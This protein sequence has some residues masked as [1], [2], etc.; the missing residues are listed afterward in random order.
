MIEGISWNL[1]DLEKIEK[2]WS[3]FSAFSCGGGSSLG[4]KMA[5]FN[6]VGAND[7]DP[8]MEWHYKKNLHPA[9]YFLCPVKHL[10]NKELPEEM[11]RLDIL[12]GSP[13]CSTF[14][15]AGNREKDWGKKKK[16]REGQAVQ[17]LDEL[18]FDF[19]ALANK[20]KPKIVVAE[21]VPGIIKG[22]AKFYAKKICEEFAN[23]GYDTQ[24]FLLNAKNCSVPQ[25]RERVFFISARSELGLPKLSLSPK[26]KQI[27]VWDAIKDI[28]NLTNE[29]IRSTAPAKIDLDYWHKVK[30]GECYG[31]AHIKGS[32]FSHRRLNADLPAYTLTANGRDAKHPTECRTLSFREFKRLSSF[33]DDYIA[34]NEKIGK[35]ICGMCVP[36]KMMCAI[37]EA[38]KYQWLQ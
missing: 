29:E 9:N 6:I 4:Y 14:S 28:Q 16:F 5:G 18:F 31:K 2:K 26:G 37:A 24:V 30:Q 25:A 3:V 21:N 23:A 11:Y 20:L 1:S 12:D 13:P 15:M 8:E 38:I 17:V 33:P 32:F 22:N 7:I 34:R 27:S 10:A 36:P 35:Y 19:I